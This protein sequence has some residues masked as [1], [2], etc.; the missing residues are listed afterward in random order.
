MSF[1]GPATTM[2]GPDAGPIVGPIGLS[3]MSID[4]VVL[5][6]FVGGPTGG[7]DGPIDDTVV[8]DDVAVHS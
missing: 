6:G 4:E 8:V 7:P 3:M 1:F 2:G 5:L